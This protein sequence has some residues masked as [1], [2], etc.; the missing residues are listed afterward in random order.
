MY[1]HL[2]REER[3]QIQSL[4]RAQHSTTEIARL[5]GRHPSTI[6][7]EIKR[8]RGAKG[9]R[10]EQACRKAAHR[11]SHS[12]N[13]KAIAPTLWQRIEPYIRCDWSPEQ[14]V[15]HFP[16]SHEAVYLRIYADK[17]PGGCLHKHLRSQKPRRKRLGA[18]QDRRG[19]SKE[20][21]H[22]QQIDQAL[23]LQTYF[24]DPYS[25]WQRG[26]NEN[27]NGLLRQYVPKKRA[28]STVTQEEL[29]MIENRLN[30]RPRKRLGF[31]TPYEVFH[32]SLKRVAVRT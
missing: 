16:I 25:S 28:L 26:S 13:A 27:F 2:S 5:L 10:A 8:G 32:A 9:Y 6:S 1:K 30:H 15:G 14:I 19:K 12:R 4:V 18:G 20:F 29:T 17:A 11:A 21:S 7:R 3:Y 24:A 22:H 31:K 23:G